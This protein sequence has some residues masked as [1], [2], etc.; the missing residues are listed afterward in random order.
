MGTVGSQTT[1]VIGQASLFR[2]ELAGLVL[3][4]VQLATT[5][6]GLGLEVGDDSA[7]GEP[8]TLPLDPTMSLGDHRGQAAGSLAQ[9]LEPDQRVAQIVATVI[10]QLALV[11]AHLGGKPLECGSC[12]RLVLG[13]FLAGRTQLAQRLS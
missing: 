12:R 13:S 6:N 3:D 2:R 11:A 1:F 9:R 4:D 10:G 8:G 5:S 7:V